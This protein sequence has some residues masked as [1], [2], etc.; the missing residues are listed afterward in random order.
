MVILPTEKRIDW[1]RPPFIVLALVV[2]NAIIFIISNGHDNRT[3][4]KTLDYYHTQDMLDREWPAYVDFRLKANDISEQEL[5]AIKDITEVKGTREK[6][7]NKTSK[8]KKMP[9]GQ[10]EQK[11][12]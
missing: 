11:S 8:N 9:R 2:I 6:Q 10:K 12:N 4:Q 7:I 3:Y 5:D 1:N